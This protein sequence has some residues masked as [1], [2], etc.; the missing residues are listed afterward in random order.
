MYRDKDTLPRCVQTDP[1]D[2]Q[3]IKR[4][5][6]G[7]KSVF[8]ELVL[9]YQDCI[10]RLARRYVGNHQDAQDVTQEAFLKAYQGLP[11]FKRISQF[12][13]WL[14]RITVN[15]CIDFNRRCEKDRVVINALEPDSLSKI[16]LTAFHLRP[17]SKMVLNKELSDQLHQAVMQLSP[18]QRE[19]FILHYHEGLSLKAIAQKLKRAVGTI[20]SHLFFARERLQN[21]LRPYV[22]V[23]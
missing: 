3:L 15:C 4:F 17:P 9:R 19:T 13:T 11:S 10:Y 18:M 16:N 20:K 6:R 5:Q 12:Y 14:Y 22:Q 8:D 21:E 1:D 2:A 23:E 7:E